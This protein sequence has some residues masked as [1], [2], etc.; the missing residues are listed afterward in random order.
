MMSR[1]PDL[2]QFTKDPGAALDFGRTRAKMYRTCAMLGL[3][4]GR[5][6]GFATSLPAGARSATRAMA[7]LADFTA[8]TNA[9]AEK[10]LADFVGKPVF[11]ANVASL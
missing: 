1:H 7:S 8:T 6:A 4:L 11:I 9:G 10:P 2:E 5:T 3:T